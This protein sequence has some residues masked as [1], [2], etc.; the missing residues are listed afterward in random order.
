ML[1]VGGG[2]DQSLPQ[3]YKLYRAARHEQ[4]GAGHFFAGGLHKNPYHETDRVYVIANVYANLQKFIKADSFIF[5]CFL[6]LVLMLWLLALTNEIK[7][8]IK[9]AE[10]C[11]VFPAVEGDFGLEI[12]KDEEG[13]EKYTITGI[14]NEHRMV[15]GF[16][17][18]IR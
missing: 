12:E 9:L 18:L 15:I 8:M 4:C 10:F 13:N 2:C 5:Q 1:K 6:F 14:L 3:I 7:E 11:V 17:C 16:V